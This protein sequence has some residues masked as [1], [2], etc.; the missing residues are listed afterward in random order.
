MNLI[1][2]QKEMRIIDIERLQQ[3]QLFLVELF[4][5]LFM[6]HR[7][8]EKQLVVL[9]KHLFVQLMMSVVLIKQKKFS[10][11]KKMWDLKGN[12]VKGQGILSQ[13]VI[14]GNKLF[15]N[16]TTESDDQADTLVTLLG[17]DKDIQVYRGSWQENF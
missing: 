14:S 10:L 1:K 8:K 13:F 9:V 12:L 6:S 15:A 17:S 16:V 4:T 5:I 2:I 3:Y 11:Q 7:Q